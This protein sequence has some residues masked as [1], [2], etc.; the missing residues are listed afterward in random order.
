MSSCTK[1]TKHMRTT[2]H[3]FENKWYQPFIDYIPSLSMC[4]PNDIQTQTTNCFRINRSPDISHL[5]RF[6]RQ[7]CRHLEYNWLIGSR[8]KHLLTMFVTMPLPYVIQSML[9]YMSLWPSNK[10]LDWLE[11]VDGRLPV[12]YLH[13][14]G[15]RLIVSGYKSVRN[16]AIILRYD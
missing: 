9:L 1:N 4:T 8:C 5:R 16:K 15:W 10:R 7:S 12:K 6:I 3:M 2:H 14:I 13:I 11:M